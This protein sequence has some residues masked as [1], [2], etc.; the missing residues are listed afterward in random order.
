MSLT[1][2]RPAPP[3]T[4]SYEAFLDWADEDTLA[5]WVDGQVIMAS[6]AN[7]RHQFIVQFLVK[8]LSA[9]VDF[10]QLG[11]VLVAPFQM[12]LPR[13]G[14]EPDV[15]FVAQEHRDRLKET[16]L[17]GPADLAVEMISSD[18]VTR[19]RERKFAEYQE[20]GVSEYWL[21]DPDLQEAELY[22]LDAQGI[23]QRILPD[24]LGSFHSQ[25]VPG[26]W[27][28]AGWLWQF[29]LPDAEDVLLDIIG[30]PYADYRRERMR[31]RGL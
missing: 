20:G 25:A 3:G 18:S 23:Y 31:Q 19:D 6:P 24:A 16:Y 26:F 15:V 30:K 4:M 10:H 13:S 8:V 17:D 2:P 5:E 11:V 14:R 29:P 12:K 28:R 7:A 22:Q 27:L 9:Y 1:H 21:L